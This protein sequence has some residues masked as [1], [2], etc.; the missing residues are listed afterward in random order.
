[1]LVKFTFH[2][3]ERTLP[4]RIY[5]HGNMVIAL[6]LRHEAKWCL[7]PMT[8]K[9]TCLG[10]VFKTRQVAKAMAKT[11]QSL[12]LVCCC[13][14]AKLSPTKLPPNKWFVWSSTSS[15]IMSWKLYKFTYPGTHPMELMQTQWSFP[16]CRSC[17][18]SADTTSKFLAGPSVGR[19]KPSM[20]GFASCRST[21]AMCI[22][23]QLSHTWGL[24]IIW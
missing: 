8:S 24:R 22:I 21:W 9:V 4:R 1:M 15:L 13:T 10:S 14:G 20:E 3:Y 7:I 19:W 23:S 6:F 17:M 2:C 5:K 16:V 12:P 18:N 11:P